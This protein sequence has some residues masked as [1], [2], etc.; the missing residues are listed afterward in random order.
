MAN[1]SAKILGNAIS[2]IRAQQ[3]VIANTGNNIANVNTPG[4]SRRT[5][6]LETR[7]QSGKTAGLSIGNGVDVGSIQRQVDTFVDGLLRNSTSEQAAADTVSS[8]LG[9]AE[10]LFSLDGSSSNIGN[11]LTGFFDSANELAM[12]P[13]SIELRTVFLEAG[14]TLVNA[15]TNT[16]N[17]LAQLQDEAGQRLV[18]EVNVVNNLTEQIAG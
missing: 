14:Q 8:F 5:V 7:A 4:Y 6:G 18:N 17:G 10:E 2:G 3:V 15:I 1:Y 9:R 16:Y 13:A 11:A 12:N